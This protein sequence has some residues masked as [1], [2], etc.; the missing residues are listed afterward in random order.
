MSPVS[1]PQTFTCPSRVLCSLCTSGHVYRQPLIQ[2]DAGIMP[3]QCSVIKG[4]SLKDELELDFSAGFF[5]LIEHKNR[6]ICSKVKPCIVNIS[7]FS[8]MLFYDFLLFCTVFVKD[9]CKKKYIWAGG[10]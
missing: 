6:N 7:S 9:P 2:G 8:W 10:D 5:C 3:S 1:V 4:F